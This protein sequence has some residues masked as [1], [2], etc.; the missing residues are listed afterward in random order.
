[1]LVQRE[2]SDKLQRDFY[3]LQLENKNLEHK[4]RQ[5]TSE[6]AA[7]ADTLAKRSNLSTTGLGVFD[8][9]MTPSTSAATTPKASPGQARS[10]QKARLT[11]PFWH[12]GILF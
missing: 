9:S 3:S 12:V 2:Y 10:N 11:R 4:V 8:I 7:L 1:M 5:L 6:K